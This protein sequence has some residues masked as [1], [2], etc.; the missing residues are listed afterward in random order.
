MDLH[1]TGKGSKIMETKLQKKKKKKDGANFPELEGW[2]QNYRG[3]ASK[4]TQYNQWTNL[5]SLVQHILES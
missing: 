5:R 3:N 2:P 1:L 4:N